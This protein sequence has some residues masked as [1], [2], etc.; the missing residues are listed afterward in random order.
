MKENQFTVDLG[1]MKLDD[2]QRQQINASIQKAVSG[3]LARLNVS[4][5]AV[6]IPVNKFPK[7]PILWGIIIRDYDDIVRQ[8]FRF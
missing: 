4:R 3:E 5:K 6:L 2:Q 8:D 7:F 1:D